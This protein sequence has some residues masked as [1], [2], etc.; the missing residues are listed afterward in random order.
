MVVQILN[1]SEHRFLMYKGLA[2]NAEYF[3]KIV[4][5]NTAIVD[6]GAGSIQISLVNDGK[7]IS[8]Q[9]ISIGALRVRERL[10]FFR[11]DTTHLERVMEEYISNEIDTFQNYYLFNKQIK[12]IIAIGDECAGVK[13]N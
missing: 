9:N 12:N 4:E 2:V 1:N 7:L 5:K 8:T 11:L 6:I 3:E 10:K 13:Y